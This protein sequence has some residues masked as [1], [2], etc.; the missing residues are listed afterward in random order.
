MLHQ[1]VSLIDLGLLFA[2]QSAVAYAWGMGRR[3][4]RFLRRGT[5]TISPHLAFP[6]GVGSQEPPGGPSL[7]VWLELVVL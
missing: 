4:T 3:A 7:S 1:A 2:R 6:T 5:E